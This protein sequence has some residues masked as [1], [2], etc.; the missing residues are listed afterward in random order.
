MPDKKL[1]I[2]GDGPDMKNLQAA[3]GPNIRFAGF[4]DHETVHDYVKRAKALLFASEEPFGIAVV[5][6]QASGTPVIAYG[7]GAAAEIVTDGENGVLF[8]RQD[9]EALIA[10]V[11]RFEKMSRW[12]KP[13]QIRDAAM[14]FS[15][16][17]FRTQFAQCVEDALS[18]HLQR[19]VA[20]TGPS[21]MRRTE[22]TAL[23]VT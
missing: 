6:A 16:D 17:S 13:E 20:G 15:T 23:P 1:V 19:Q 14:R 18:V 22:K 21:Y 10:A 4:V 9:A 11:N 7:K 5:E 2:I 3:A 8:H 12:F